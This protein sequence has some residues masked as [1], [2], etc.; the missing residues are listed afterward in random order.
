MSHMKKI[1]KKIVVNGYFLAC[2]FYSF[3][4]RIFRIPSSSFSEKNSIYNVSL[5]SIF[6]RLCAIKVYLDQKI[7]I[8][9]FKVPLQQKI[10]FKQM[11]QEKQHVYQDLKRTLTI[12]KS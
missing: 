8:F 9:I 1:I 12:K 5:L 11:S 3:A 7:P 2:Y 10:I 4:A 6:N